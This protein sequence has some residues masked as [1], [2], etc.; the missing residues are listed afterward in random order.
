MTAPD[1]GLTDLIAA[2]EP[3]DRWTEFTY[4]PA[5]SDKPFVATS[6]TKMVNCSC[7]DSMPADDHPAHV[8]LVVEQHTNGR[9]AELEAAVEHWKDRSQYNY[10]C[11]MVLANEANARAEKAEATIASVEAQRVQFDLNGMHI[12]A[13]G[14]R[15]A[16]EWEQQ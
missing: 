2:H 14:L 11:G 5:F 1:P 9:T 7:G 10:D 15:A 4:P 16:L 8:A 6:V 3:G 13:N 12:A